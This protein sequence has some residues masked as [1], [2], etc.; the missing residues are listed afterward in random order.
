[1]DNRSLQ[2]RKEQA[3]APGQTTLTPVY[4]E[5]ACNAE[6]WD[7]EGR[8]YIDLG[9]GIAV[10]NTGHNHP[11]VRAAVT[12]QIEKFEHTCLTVTPYASAVELAEKLNALVPGP[13]P[14]KSILV[15]TGAEALENAIKIARAYTGRSHSIAF[16]G[17]FHGRTNLALG[18]T[19]IEEPYKPG[20]GP[21]PD[22]IHHLPYPNAYH[23]IAVEYAV[24]ALDRL[25]T[26]QVAPEQVAALLIEPLQGE[27]GF[28]AAPVEFLQLLRERCDRYGIMLVCDEVQSGFARTGRMFAVQYSGIEPDLV[29]MAK[30]LA[31]G[32]PLAAVTGRA[33][34]MDATRPGGLGGTYGGS[35]IGCAAALAVLDVIERES[36]CERALDVGDAYI[37][38]LQAMQARYPQRIGDVRHLGAMIAMELVRDG[39]A[40]QPD[41]EAVQAV[42]AAAADLGLILLYCGVRRNVIRLLPPLTIS[43]ELIAESLDILE[44]A[45]AAVF[46]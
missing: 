31:A 30:G 40:G 10:L 36:L 33:E 24:Q 26:E 12:A 46:G 34:V 23:G 13:S 22:T 4:I 14:K 15:T 2:D 21:F 25:L 42:L 44:K 32:F 7:V 6:L 43:D 20:F 9:T 3:F 35:P 8:R 16:S 18:L 29:T 19:G 1:M 38:R 39:D 17:A 28:Y 5:R 27:G 37:S 45:L 41:P 11:A